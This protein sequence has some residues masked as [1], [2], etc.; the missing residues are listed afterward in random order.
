MLLS[1]GLFGVSF[2]VNWTETEPDCDDLMILHLSLAIPSTGI[3]LGIVGDLLAASAPS[4][5]NQTYCYDAAESEAMKLQSPSF[6]IQPI[7]FTCLA[8][9]VIA[10]VVQIQKMIQEPSA[11]QETIP[12]Q[13]LC[14]K[15]FGLPEIALSPAKT[16]VVPDF[17]R[18][19]LWGFV[20]PSKD[21]TDIAAPVP[22]TYFGQIGGHVEF[23]DPVYVDTK[24]VGWK[25]N[26]S[27]FSTDHW[28]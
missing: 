23:F 21:S 13:N 26:R 9:C 27:L 15:A 19:N 5:H 17:P 4:V 22:Q 7:I 20:H 11:T 24:S 16:A 10:V 6:L 14:L 8:Y 2:S 28:Y 1:F 3:P 12:Q 18:A 25:I